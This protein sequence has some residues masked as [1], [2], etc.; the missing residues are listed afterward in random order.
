MPP[1]RA[2]LSAMPGT[3]PI[4][5]AQR[6]RHAAVLLLVH[7]LLAGIAPLA[8]AAG[9]PGVAGATHIEASGEA[10]CPAAHD[11]ER[12]QTC[13]SF[14]WAATPGPDTISRIPGPAQPPAPLAAEE[15]VL[16]RSAVLA[17]PSTR[18]PPAA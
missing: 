9:T 4:V 16:A 18:A 3:R 12:C 2:F 14:T 7:L 5:H 6:R 13:R 1:A 8:H 11:H 10:G 15:R 17:P